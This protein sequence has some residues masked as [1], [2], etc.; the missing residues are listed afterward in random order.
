MGNLVASVLIAISLS[1]GS[2]GTALAQSGISHASAK[3]C[4]TRAC[5]SNHARGIEVQAGG[6]ASLTT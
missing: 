5:R 6:V 2:T 3:R 1:L 4:P